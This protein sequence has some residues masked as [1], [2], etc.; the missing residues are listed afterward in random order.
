MSRSQAQ[1]KRGARAAA[2]S[3]SA[4]WSAHIDG[5]GDF[6]ERR[7]RG[8]AYLHE[9]AVLEL[10]VEPGRISA[11]VQG[12]RVYRPTIVVQ[13][14]APAMRA[15]FREFACAEGCAP[16]DLLRAALTVPRC[17]VLPGLRELA[18]VCTCPDH[19][20]WSRGPCKHLF[21]ALYAVGPRLDDDPGLLFTLRGVELAELAGAS[22]VRRARRGS[23]ARP[24]ARGVTAP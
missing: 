17:G 24:A 19:L 2:V 22:R 4:A 18:M 13:P 6:A 10:K 12:S 23:R 20:R 7:E 16:D 11:R 3:C 1:A 9:G 14:L 21:A 5:F 8:R 15:G